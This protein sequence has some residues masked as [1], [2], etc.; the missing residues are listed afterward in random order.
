MSIILNRIAPKVE[1]ILSETQAGFRKNRSTVEQITNL[2]VLCEKR[3]NVSNPVFHNFIDFKKA[4]VRV[5]HNRM[6]DTL[7]KFNIGKRM[8]HLMKQLYQKAR[9]KVLSGNA[10]SEWFQATVGV[11]QGCILSP[12]LF[13]LF[14]ERIMLDALEDFEEGIKCGGKT[15]NNLRFADDIDLMAGKE[16]HLQ[17]LTT[18]LDETSKRYG[19]EVST[20]KSKTMITGGQDATLNIR[21]GNNQLEHVKK[22]CYLG[23]TITQNETSDQEIKERIGKATSALV[24]LSNIWKSKDIKITNKIYFLRTLVISIFLYGCEAWTLSVAIRRKIDAFEMKAYRRLLNI[25][26][27]D[28]RT[29]ESVWEEIRRKS[30]IDNMKRLIT[31]VE[32]RKFKFFGHQIRADGLTKSIIQGCVA[33]ERKRGRP[34]RVWMDDLKE[35]SG[36]GTQQLCHETEDRNGWRDSVDSWVHRR[37]LGLRN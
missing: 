34:K 21:I 12:I 32:E 22:F 17:T 28:R 25:T 29:N 5:W 19:M 6:F 14:L 33:G 36:L 24:K 35:W 18:R 13:N 37:P 3:R 7:L 4:F 16:E 23:S 27:K 9:T 30:K 11:R 31:I 20:E 10:Y 26:W 8:T 2:R 1:S 15:V